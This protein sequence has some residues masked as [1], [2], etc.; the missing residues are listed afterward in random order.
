[1]KLSLQNYH[2]LFYQEGLV[3]CD[4]VYSCSVTTLMGAQLLVVEPVNIEE[5][6]KN[7]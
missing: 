5:H 6:K 1:M 3:M 2:Y 4:F 7:P